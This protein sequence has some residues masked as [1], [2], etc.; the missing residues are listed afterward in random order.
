MQLSKVSVSSIDHYV[1]TDRTVRSEWW[2]QGCP[3]FLHVA[4][5]ETD[6]VKGGKT[7]GKPKK[8]L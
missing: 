1:F 2:C 3:V 7:P 8:D 6:D 4:A 5:E